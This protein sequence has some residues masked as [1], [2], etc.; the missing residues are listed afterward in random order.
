MSAAPALRRMLLLSCPRA[1]YLLAD[2]AAGL[3]ADITSSSR[4]VWSG[5]PV[6]AASGG[7]AEIGYVSNN[8]SA[9]AIAEYAAH[10][11]GA[12]ARTIMAVLRTLDTDGVA[13]EFGG[14]GGAGDAVVVD[15]ASSLSWRHGGNDAVATTPIADGD[16]HVVICRADAAGH[17]RIQV[18]GVEVAS[19]VFP[20]VLATIPGALRVFRQTSAATP[21][22][23]VG[24]LACAAVWDRELADHEV[25]AFDALLRTPHRLAGVAA[26]D[27]GTPARRVLVRR[28]VDHAHLLTVVPE[29][30]TGVWDAIVP[31]GDYEITCTG[32]AGYLPQIFVPVG[33]VPV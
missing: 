4:L 2:T 31:A 23:L 9:E 22:R 1:G 27:D 12:A 20:G 33:A 6:V 10:P 21:R 28:A 30:P 17:Y 8:G 3:T 5:G 15:A 19:G 16:W 24:D 29:Q 32:P 14:D 13:M 11:L 18:D 7:P 25:A 26:L